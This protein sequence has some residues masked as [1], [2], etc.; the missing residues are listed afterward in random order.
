MN[1]GGVDELVDAGAKAECNV[2]N[3]DF[4]EDFAEAL[5]D[6]IDKIRNRVNRGEDII[7]YIQD[8]NLD[9][10]VNRLEEIVEDGVRRDDIR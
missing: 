10:R 2:A 5:R 9:N 4:N 8:P 6:S 1:C 7:P 3:R